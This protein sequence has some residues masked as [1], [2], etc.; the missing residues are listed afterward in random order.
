MKTSFNVRF[1]V[2]GLTLGCLFIVGGCNGGGAEP[3]EGVAQTT[4]GGEAGHDHDHGAK[5]EDFASAMKI[6]EGYSSDIL[7]AFKDGKPEEAHD[8]LHS[9]GHLLESLPELAMKDKE[10]GDEAKTQLNQAVESLFDSFTKLDGTLHGGEAADVDAVSED[11]NKAMEQ[12][13]SAM[14]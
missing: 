8:A 11:V 1:C 9:I 3:T 7:T 2:V 14:Q 12:L 10:L 6:L 5:P 13:R 4:A